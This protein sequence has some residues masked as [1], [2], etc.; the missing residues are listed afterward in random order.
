MILCQVDIV[1]NAD[2]SAHQTA[3][4]SYRP[5]QSA[6][7]P[8]YGAPAAAP[9]YGA[10]AGAGSSYGNINPPTYGGP[11]TYG[12]AH[13]GS[14]QGS[15][16]APAGYGAPTAGYGAPA[17]APVSGYGAPAPAAVGGYGASGAY[18][19]AIVRDDGNATITPIRDINP[20]SN[21]WTIKARV[22]R[23]AGV[24]HWSNPKGEGTLFSIDLLDNQGSEIRATFFKE[25]CEK[26]YPLIEELKTYTFS[27]GKLKVVT[28]NQYSSFKSTYEITFD[29]TSDIRPALD[30]DSIK[31]ATF[32]FIKIAQIAPLD[33]GSVCDVIGIV[34]Q[35]GEIAD[36]TTKDGKTIKKRDLFLYDDSN[37]EVRM[38]IWNDKAEDTKIQW[39]GSIVAFKGCKVGDYQGKNL[40][41]T[42]TSQIIISPEIPEGFALHSWLQNNPSVASR[43][44][45]LSTSGSG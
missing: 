30:D 10:G 4:P 45:S 41:T 34:R 28:N 38:T 21:K 1:G 11:P 31:K 15:Y 14:A 5:P 42:F 43:L 24:K 16:G 13:Q 18:G 32:K 20:Y 27:G 26:F 3:P 12:S 35:A 8:S 36:I 25:A 22:T 39:E 7:I 44:V 33:P 23:K 29:A 40:G 6:A 17:P 2:Q 37:T 9:S 19:K